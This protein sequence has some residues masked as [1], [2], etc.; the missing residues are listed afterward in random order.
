MRAGRWIGGVSL[1]VVKSSDVNIIYH[2]RITYN[3]PCNIDI[4]QILHHHCFQ[5]L[6]GTAVPRET[7]ENAYA[8]K[9]Y[10]GQWGTLLFLFVCFVKQTLNFFLLE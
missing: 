3:T 5:F 8:N 1:E 7:E 2:F 6:L 10:Y 9:V 4:P